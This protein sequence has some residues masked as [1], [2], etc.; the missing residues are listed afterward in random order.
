MRL[1]GSIVF[2]LLLLSLDPASAESA[3]GV[4]PVLAPLE[5]E[6]GI[7]PAPGRAA[8]WLQ[9]FICAIAPVAVARWRR[10]PRRPTA[11]V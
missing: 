8:Q 2:A 3:A 6:A 9:R 1:A 10:G 4:S 7:S 5:R 11:S